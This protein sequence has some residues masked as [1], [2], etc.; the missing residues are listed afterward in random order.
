[1]N[2]QNEKCVMEKG[3]FGKWLSEREK[4]LKNISDF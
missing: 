4:Q 2:L 3:R 1:M